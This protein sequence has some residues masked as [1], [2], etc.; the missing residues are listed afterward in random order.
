M[1]NFI[2]AGW[3]TSGGISW[4]LLVAWLMGG[5]LV[6]N[7][8]PEDCCRACFMVRGRGA[9]HPPLPA[10]VIEELDHLV[11]RILRIVDHIGK[12]FAQV[13]IEKFS[14]SHVYG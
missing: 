10:F 13:I 14:L 9:G 2:S 8:A 12:G 5:S 4:F 7:C 11:E 6:K 3:M 1:E